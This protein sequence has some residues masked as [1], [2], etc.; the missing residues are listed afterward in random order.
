MV[1]SRLES[2]KCPRR[3]IFG[4]S[5]FLQFLLLFSIIGGNYIWGWLRSLAVLML[6]KSWARWGRKAKRQGKDY[7]N[8]IGEIP[9]FSQRHPLA[10]ERAAA[11][12]WILSQHSVERTSPD[13]SLQLCF[14]VQNFGFATV[15]EGKNF[16]FVNFQG[17]SP[18]ELSSSFPHFFLFETQS[19]LR[20]RKR[21]KRKEKGMDSSA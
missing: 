11:T 2:T 3:L 16:S 12:G 18:K 17:F 7:R 10:S 8:C 19:T 5:T 13:S 20:K 4:P 15:A 21:K 14:T 6:Y 9:S 1:S